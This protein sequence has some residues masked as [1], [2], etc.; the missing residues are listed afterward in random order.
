MVG[1]GRCGRVSHVGRGRARSRTKARGFDHTLHSLYHK[2]TFQHSTGGGFALG[3]SQW[4]VGRCRITKDLAGDYRKITSK[5]CFG[6]RLDCAGVLPVLPCHGGGLEAFP[7]L[8]CIE[9]ARVMSHLS[10]R[11]H[12]YGFYFW[13][14]RHFLPKCWHRCAGEVELFPC[15]FLSYLCVSE[16]C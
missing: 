2:A 1:S 12:R 14:S 15:S 10:H 8:L 6:V 5:I 7:L 4:N 13:V 3:T 9:L 11:L 16:L